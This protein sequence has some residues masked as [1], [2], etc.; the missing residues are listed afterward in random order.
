MENLMDLYVHELR[1]LHN[2]ESQ[3]INALPKMIKAATHDELRN[4]FEDHFEK[5]KKQKE[6]LENIFSDLN[7][8]PNDVKCKGIEGIIKESEELL[9]ND[10]DSE[11][12]DAV[13]IASAQRVEHYEM[14][15]YGTA[16]SF[17]ARLGR[18]HDV[19]LL[20]ETLDEEGEA[21]YKLTSIAERIVNAEAATA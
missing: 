17:A 14:A 10:T 12:L 15:A 18:S 21:D 13:L 4:A 7:E 11:V 5:T 20:Q 2:A 3:I 8:E 9:K 19:R 1:D 6:R 16:R